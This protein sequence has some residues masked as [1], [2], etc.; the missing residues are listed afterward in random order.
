M[1]DPGRAERR[2]PRHGGGVDTP[3]GPTGRRAR[4]LAETGTVGIQRARRTGA[5][6]VTTSSRSPRPEGLAHLFPRGATRSREG[7]GGDPCT[8]PGASAVQISTGFIYGAPGTV[9]RILRE[10]EALLRR[11]GFASAGEA[12]GAD[13]RA[14][15]QV[16]TTRSPI[17]S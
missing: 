2:P 10:L 8:N 16:P 3:S 13:L 6:T 9:K 1:M 17:P 15:E 14:P 5:A 7:R 11:D 4:P 12:V